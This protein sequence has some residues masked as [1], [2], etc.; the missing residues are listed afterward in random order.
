MA[1]TITRTPPPS[2][3]TGFAVAADYGFE[4]CYNTE[5][6]SLVDRT[7][8]F[9]NGATPVESFVA[10]GDYIYLG[11]MP[12]RTSTAT[13]GYD[14]RF[15]SVYINLSVVASSSITPVFEYQT[16]D[17][18][19]R[20]FPAI[21]D[22]TS[23]FTQNGEIS[24][25]MKST[26]LPIAA[27]TNAWVRGSQ[28]GSGNEIGDGVDRYYMRIKRTATSLT[29]PPKFVEV[30]TGELAANTAFYYTLFNTQLDPN[31]T[32]PTPVF[33]MISEGSTELSATTTDYK[34]C[35]KLTFDAGTTG[36]YKSA[37]RT[38][39]AG[40]YK[41]AGRSLYYWSQISTLP[42]MAK[43]WYFCYFS[44][45]CN[46]NTTTMIMDDGLFENF[47]GDAGGTNVSAYYAGLQYP[48]HPRGYILVSGGTSATPATFNDILNADIAGGWNTF[49]IPSQQATAAFRD[50]SCYDNLKIVDYFTDSFCSLNMYGQITVVPGSTATAGLP[51]A[52]FGEKYSYTDAYT[53]GTNTIYRKGVEFI[54]SGSI[55]S[56]WTDIFYDSY[57]YNCR[58]T[59]NPLDNTYS[60][61]NRTY[62]TFP[63]LVRGGMYDT[64]LEGLDQFEGVTFGGDGI[65]LDGLTLNYARYGLFFTSDL[66]NQTINNVTVN[67]ANGM[68]YNFNNGMTINLKNMTFKVYS[69]FI[70]SYLISANQY[71]T[72]TWN[73]VNPTL[74]LQ[75]P[76]SVVS[77]SWVGLNHQINIQYETDVRIVD[78]NGNAIIGATVVIT[79]NTGT[80]LFSKT[81]DVN[82]DITTSTIT[83]TNYSAGTVNVPAYYNYYADTITSKSP[84]TFTVTAPGYE[85]YSLEKSLTEKT[86]LTFT[87][88]PIKPVRH[89]IEGKFLLANK[90]ELGSESK[91]LEL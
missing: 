32:N 42:A 71:Y 74:K 54:M 40:Y 68:R 83:A 19:W 33:K 56:M 2:A 14:S 61:Q 15:I 10:N 24:V 38:P 77:K 64:V 31:N 34:R 80:E 29:T 63:Y 8:E 36:I 84:T 47:V 26:E 16:A 75:S 48:E 89:T 50:F 27:G 23:G 79:D 91:M 73:L 28:D 9:Q 22:G 65:I 81:T 45:N 20:A 11:M 39:T 44:G 66:A 17:N 87:L 62:I 49:T 7:A 3:P 12:Q 13:T 86:K 6:G 55:C 58:F 51:K 53:G 69:V 57:F 60:P 88:K 37:W 82:G 41:D 76:N 43:P 90:P 78:T 52:I 59:Q 46:L 30:G 35:I 5:S 18:T 72:M 4:K 1:V 25:S 21:T 85:N 70:L 67:G